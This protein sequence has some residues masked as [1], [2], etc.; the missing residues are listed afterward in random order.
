MLEYVASGCSYYRFNYE[1]AYKG[2]LNKFINKCLKG[3]QGVGD[4]KF[5]LLY[6]AHVEKK[7]GPMLRNHFE[8]GTYEI[9]ADS[10]GLQIITLGH[11]IT[12]E[13]KNE[14]YDNQAEFC[15]VAMSFDEIPVGT[16]GDRVEKKDMKGRF[17][18]REN[19]K[20]RAK[21]TG[22]NLRK[23]IEYFDKKESEAR[24]VFICHG[25]DL[26]TFVQWAEI[27]LKQVPKEK[28]KRIGGIAISG[29]ALGNGALEDVKRAFYYTQMPI[30][31]ITPHLHM[32]GVG[33]VLRL[34]PTLMFIHSGLFGQT[35]LSYDSTSMTSGPHYGRFYGLDGWLDYPKTMS[36]DYERMY[37]DVKANIPF[38]PHSLEIFHEGLNTAARTF[39]KKHKSIDPVLE[40]FIGLITTMIMNFQRNVQEVVLKPNKADK[41][42]SPIQTSAYLS[43][44]NVKT[45]AD[46]KHWERQA[47]KYLDTNNVPPYQ[48]ASLEDLFV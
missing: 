44:L 3:I 30:G 10:G 31:D 15:D 2:S 21:E 9:Y 7:F 32:L 41:W 23:Q 25:N 1:E 39:E 40:S 13:L 38:Y 20:E 11:D 5:S 45:L 16:V 34:V 19:F 4:H 35:R 48:P 27:A 14:V 29:A 24:P 8:E 12:E 47:G 17:F 22:I 28:R 46:F 42:C 26:D 6:N 18:D 37:K 36:Q 33:S 43:L